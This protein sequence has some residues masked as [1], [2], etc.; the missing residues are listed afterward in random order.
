M[1]E[2]KS[3]LI[4]GADLN[5]IKN[6]IKAL[7]KMNKK[8]IPRVPLIPGYTLY[9]E[10]I[11]QIIIFVKSLNLTEIHLLPFHQYG[12]NK[13]KLLNKEYKLKDIAI[14]STKDVEKVANEMRNNGLNV[15]LNG[16]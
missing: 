6:N 11:K 16:L 14:P 2:K 4:L 7:V 15:I 3:K 5:L 8:V 13:Y 1:D 12:S 10:N 9:D